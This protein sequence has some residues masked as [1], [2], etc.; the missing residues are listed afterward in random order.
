MEDYE[1]KASEL[2]VFLRQSNMEYSDCEIVITQKY[3]DIAYHIVSV[4]YDN[5]NYPP[6][7]ILL[8]DE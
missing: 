2:A 8:V 4:Q 6:R 1:M 5:T 7:V 3:D